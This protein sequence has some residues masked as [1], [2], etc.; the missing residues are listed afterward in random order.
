MAQADEFIRAHKERCMEILVREWNLD[1]A[2]LLYAWEKNRFALS[3]DQGILTALEDE[4]DWKIKESGSKGTALPNYLR[5]VYWDG[6]AAVNPK[7]VT[8]YR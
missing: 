1:P 4:A 7:A 8:I 5:F 6:L 2:Y 3:L